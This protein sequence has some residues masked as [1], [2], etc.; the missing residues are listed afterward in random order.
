MAVIWARRAFLETGW[1]KDVKVEVNPE[2]TI[3]AVESGIVRCGRDAGILLP[4]PANLHSH[5]F[6]RAMAGLAERRVE[7]ISDD[8]WSW[9]QLMYRFLSRLTPD[10]VEAIAALAQL[11]MLEAGFGRCV[12]FHYLHHSPD[13]GEFEDLAEMSG[14]IASA[15]SRTGIGLTLLPVLYQFGGCDRRPLDKS[16]ARFGND[17]DRFLR[18]HQE[19]SDAVASV[20]ADASTGVAFHSL[21]AVAPSSIRETLR[22]LPDGPVHIHAAEQLAEVDEIVSAYGA[23]PVEWLLANADVDRRWCLIHCTQMETSETRRLASSGA[24]AGLCPITEAN[25]GDGIFDGVRYSGHGGNFGFGTDSNVEISLSGELRMLEYSQRLR[26]R[27]R[28][29]IS[30]AGKSAGRRLFE[31]A[32]SG[33]ALAA[34]RQC[35]KIEV[36]AWADL[37]SL[38]ADGLELAGRTGDEILDAFVFSGGDRQIDDVWSA[39]RR[40]VRNGRH[41]GRD[42]IEANFKRTM[43]ELKSGL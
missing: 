42:G 15:A 9:R 19:A 17:C 18:L 2:G 27:S 43:K 32:L 26:D 1:A 10:Q 34:G 29:R 5:A 11:E 35:G 22:E 24:V 40:V 21:R 4:A 30:E 36:G 12:E 20:S 23:R 38:R 31:A 16:Q 13:G 28:L 33:G 3:G 39:G 37:F 7:S 25:L 6:Q 8:F 14:R 41:I